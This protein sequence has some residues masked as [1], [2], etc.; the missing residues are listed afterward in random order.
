[1]A[2]GGIIFSDDIEGGA[3]GFSSGSI[4]SISI[5]PLQGLSVVDERFLL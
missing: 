5:A 1:M 3:I 4:A 2:E